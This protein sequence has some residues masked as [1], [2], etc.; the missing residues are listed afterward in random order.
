MNSLADTRRSPGGP[1]AKTAL[2]VWP[3]QMPLLR[4][5][6]HAGLLGGAG[7]RFQVGPRTVALGWV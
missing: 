6:W 4:Q 3:L 5:A 1:V 2:G 7:Q